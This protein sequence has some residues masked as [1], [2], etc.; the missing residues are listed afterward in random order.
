MPGLTYEAPSLAPASSARYPL[1]GRPSLDL[2]G[3]FHFD[4]DVVRKCTD[5]NRHSR[6]APRLAKDIHEQ[7]GRSIHHL[8][9]ADEV[10]RRVHIAR[11]PHS[12]NDSIQI[13]LYRDAQVCQEIQRAE[14]CR[15]LPL[16]NPELPAKLPDEAALAVPLRELPG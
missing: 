4:G 11:E 5:S 10:G 14:P 2:E 6:M 12:P 3:A 1:L 15:L 13:P 7:V 8:R 16:G 9:L